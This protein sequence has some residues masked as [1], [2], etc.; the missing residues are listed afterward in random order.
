MEFGLA[1]PAVWSVSFQPVT[2]PGRHVGFDPLTRLTNS[3][4]IGLIAAQRPDWFRAADFFPCHVVPRLPLGHLP[5]HGGN[6]GPASVSCQ[7]L[8]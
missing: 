7:S 5:A 8:A 4:V 6:A 2:H 1:H 3:D